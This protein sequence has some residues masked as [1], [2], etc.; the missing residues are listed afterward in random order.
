[1]TDPL[2][3]ILAPFALAVALF[4][5][6]CVISLLIGD[7]AR[8]FRMFAARPI[9]DPADEARRLLDEMEAQEAP[10]PG[11]DRLEEVR[12]LSAGREG[13]EWDEI[14]TRM[15]AIEAASFGRDDA[16]RDP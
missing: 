14:R 12:R 1:M 13:R 11:G 8:P 3:Y 16:G 15:R 7:P 10:P 2:F 6:F 5:V 9:A 4:A